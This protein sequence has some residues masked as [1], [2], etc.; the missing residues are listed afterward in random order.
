MELL[1]GDQQ[2]MWQQR[3]KMRSIIIP[4]KKNQMKILKYKLEAELGG[5]S[6]EVVLPF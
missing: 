3:K 6:I 5:R 4:K 1:R 2:E